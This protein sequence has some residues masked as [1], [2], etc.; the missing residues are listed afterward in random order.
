MIALQLERENLFRIGVQESSP[1]HTHKRL[2]HKMGVYW[3]VDFETKTDDDDDNHVD[4]VR[5]R[6]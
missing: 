6:L 2:R 1:K 3:K 4:G 5:L